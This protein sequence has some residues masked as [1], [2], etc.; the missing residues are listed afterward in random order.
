MTTESLVAC[1]NDTIERSQTGELKEF[2]ERAISSNCLYKENFSSPDCGRQNYADSASEKILVVPDSTF[3]AAQKNIRYGKTAVLNFAN[4]QYPGGGTSK[5]AVAQ[6]ECLCRCSNL[7]LCLSAPNIFED[8]YFYHKKYT[9]HLFSDRLIYTKDV[10]VF[11]DESEVPALLPRDEWFFVDVITCAAPYIAK[12]NIDNTSLK[13]LFKSRIKNIFEAAIDN[14]VEVIILGAFGC[15]AFKNPPEVVAEAFHEVID[16]NGY[17]DN[18]RKIVFAIKCNPNNTK[19]LD[20]FQEEFS[21]DEE[22]SACV[23]LPWLNDLRE[24]V[25]NNPEEFENYLDWKKSNKYYKKHFSILGDS[26]STL[27]GCNPKG[28]KVFYADENCEKSAVKE[29]QDTWWGKV[30]DFFGGEL[31]VNNS[32][33]GSRV[34][35]LPNKYYFSDN[36]FPSGCSNERTG[37]LH[38]NGVKPDVIIVYLGTNDWANGIPTL[39]YWENSGDYENWLGTKLLPNEECFDVAY[40]QMLTKLSSNYPN[41]EIWCCTLCKSFMSSNPNFVFPCSYAGIHIDKYNE[42]IRVAAQNKGCKI[43]DIASKEIEYDAFDGTH[44]NCYGME[45]LAKGM[46]VEAVREEMGQAEQEFDSVC[47]DEFVDQ[48]SDLERMYK[49][50]KNSTDDEYRVALLSR[51]AD[52]LAVIPMYFPIEVDVES[53]LNGIDPSQLKPGDVITPSEAPKYH[54]KKLDP[55]VED[56]V[57]K[58]IVPMFTTKEHLNNFYSDGTSCIR[59]YPCDY[60]RGVVLS[61]DYFFINPGDDGFAFTTLF[62]NDIVM[63]RALAT[64]DEATD[65][66]DEIGVGTIIE[67]KYKIVKHIARGGAFDTYLA[68]DT[69]LNLTWA[70]KVSRSNRTEDMGLIQNQINILKQLDHPMIPRF[71][72]AYMTNGKAI[73]VQEYVAGT[74]LEDIVNEY[75]GQSVEHVV[76]WIGQI[77]NVMGYLHMQSQMFIYRD[78]K[79]ANFILEPSGRIRVV[80][81]DIIRS[82]K[83]G[84]TEDT[85]N[86][87]TKGYAA[88][89]QFGGRGQTD[90]RTDVYGI[91]ATMYRLLTGADV[92]ERN[93]ILNPITLDEPGIPS[94][95]A[96]IINKCTQFNPR[97][98]YNSCDELLNDLVRYNELPPKKGFLSRLKKR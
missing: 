26:I 73:I 40:D 4:P 31:L 84:R 81:F 16:E 11:K 57:I 43:I 79:P 83:P 86:L 89:E 60:L 85:V 93:I 88:P 27:A 53:F 10:V 75:G 51:I 56:G 20:V 15:G 32:W 28:Y 35:K 52:L 41:A 72:D 61:S 69:R 67:N 22:K 76:D 62:L 18:F 33:S 80:D 30:I 38:I 29:M 54:I 5:G 95:L 3:A 44:P 49:Y 63:P 87:G 97:E 36:L 14:K 94:G 70:V 7:Y 37:G 50:Y 66:N 48:I 71:A 23:E 74:T 1:F 6:E 58:K 8:Y 34:T 46:I 65:D 59:I 77:C 19:N 42:I 78:V 12:I 24:R 45:N 91:G 68:T 47:S 21:K 17:A 82:Y 90:P 2:T 64:E 39:E 96:Y 55:I 98:R 25:E 13:S 92:Q 9:N